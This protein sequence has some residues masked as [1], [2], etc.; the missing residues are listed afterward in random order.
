MSAEPMVSVSDGD[1]ESGE[2]PLWFVGECTCGHEIPEHGW[3]KCDVD[4]CPCEARYEE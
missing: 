1:E 4:G 3:Q 2:Y